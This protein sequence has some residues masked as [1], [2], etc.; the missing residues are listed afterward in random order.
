[1]VGKIGGF[2]DAGL[3]GE[4]AGRSD[5]D[6]SDIAAE[7]DDDE[8]GV[9]QI[10]DAQGDID[11]FVDQIDVP[12]QEEEPHRNGRVEIEKIVDDRPQHLLPQDRGCRNGQCPTRSGPFARGEHV[13]LLQLDQHPSTGNHVARPR[14]AQLERP[15]GSMQQLDPDM[16]FQKGKRTAD[17]SR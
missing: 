10:G 4:I 3:V 2:V 14:F 16:G 15:G 12:V 9:G 8:R 1:M 7:A 6:A 11:A 13:G 17:R 5:D